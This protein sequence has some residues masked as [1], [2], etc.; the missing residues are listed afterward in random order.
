MNYAISENRLESL[1]FNYFDKNFGS[2]KQE[3]AVDDHGNRTECAFEFY[4]ED[5]YSGDNTV[6]RLYEKCWWNKDETPQALEMWE[7]SPIL[8]FDYQQEYNVLEGYFGEYWKEPFKKWFTENFGIEIK[9][10]E[11]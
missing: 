1:L 9:T 7:K 4:N 8:I 10:I 3:L 6:F 5:L 2:L 11:Y